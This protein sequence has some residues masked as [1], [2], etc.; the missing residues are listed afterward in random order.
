MVKECAVN[1]DEIE[2]R[3]DINI[4]MLGYYDLLIRMDWLEKH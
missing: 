1:V 3:L 2:T 4:L